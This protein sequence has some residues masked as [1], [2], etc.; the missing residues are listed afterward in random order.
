[1]NNIISK[2]DI[3]NIVRNNNKM[4]TFQ[5]FR[6]Q[7]NQDYTEEE[8]K[9]NAFF[10]YIDKQEY[11]IL[12]DRII[13][14]LGYKKMKNGDDLPIDKARFRIKEI[15]KSKYHIS[16]QIIKYKDVS[17]IPTYKNDHMETKGKNNLAQIKFYIFS[18]DYFIALC[19]LINKPEAKDIRTFFIKVR[20]L[21][22]AYI[23]YQTYLLKKEN[24]S[25]KQ[26]IKKCHIFKTK[27]FDLYNNIWINPKDLS[28]FLDYSNKA[29]IVKHVDDINKNII[30]KTLMINE[31]GLKQI[32]HKSSKPKITKLCNI[33]NI[34]I[35]NDK[36]L[37][38]ETKYI[39][40]IMKSFEG[41]NIEDQYIVDLYRIDLYFIDYKLAI[42]CD[43]FDHIDRNIDDE[44]ER[45]DY[46][47][48]KLNC[49]FIR[50][51]PDSKEFDIFNIINQIFKYIKTYN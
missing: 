19:F 20:R 18:P 22:S 50:F 46:I 31:T 42:E 6:H 33:L 25:L 8:A 3:K 11:I 30:D 16:Y 2:E 1:M 44:K 12:T 41:E 32:I 43:E 36:N 10:D 48:N 45:E 13:R 39:S 24:I 34:N 51:N 15:L 21:M 23:I 29:N 38:K 14:Y 27:I 40:K 35:L 4:L 7:L 47:S 26:K 5:D 17:K 49:K 37:R 28:N 9:I